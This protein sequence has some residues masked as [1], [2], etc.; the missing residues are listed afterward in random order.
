[1]QAGRAHHRGNDFAIRLDSHQRAEGRNAARKLFR[2]VDRVD[3]HARP[4]GSTR[5]LRVA[6]AHF[7]SK[8][9][10]RQSACRYFRPRHFFH[11]AIRLR[12]RRAVAFSVNAQFIGAEIPH[13]NRIRLLR[14]RLQQSSVL[15]PVT[16]CLAHDF[17]WLENLPLRL[18]AFDFQLSTVN[19][20][21]I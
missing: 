20:L 15:F 12:H 9:V 3:D 19:F 5:R 18:S 14:D 6:A 16:H 1:M 10:Q 7:F 8:N 13:R 11:S 17:P 21:P 2:S 4:P